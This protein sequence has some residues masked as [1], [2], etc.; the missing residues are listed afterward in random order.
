MFESYRIPPLGM[1]WP[2]SE[3]IAQIHTKRT[4]LCELLYY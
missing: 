3:D 1:E 4:P 2:L